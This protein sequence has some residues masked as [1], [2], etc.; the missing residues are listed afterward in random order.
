MCARLLTVPSDAPH[1]N[2]Y[3]HHTLTTNDLFLKDAFLVC[4][5]MCKLTM[6]PLTTERCARLSF[7]R[8]I[9]R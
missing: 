2:G 7:R 8:R 5:A 9:V 3:G 6:K 1:T 4:R